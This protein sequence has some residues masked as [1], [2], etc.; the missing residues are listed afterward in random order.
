MEVYNLFISVLDYPFHYRMFPWRQ[1]GGVS[2]N[3]AV[4]VTRNQCNPVLSWDSLT[5]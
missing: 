5:L 4:A 2:W 3:L 1:Q